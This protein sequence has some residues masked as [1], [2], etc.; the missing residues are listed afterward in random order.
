MQ[1]KH[2]AIL[3]TASC[4]VTVAGCIKDPLTVSP[5]GSYTT[6]NYWRNQTDVLAGITGIYNVLT[7]EIGRAHV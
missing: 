5:V 7:Q 4:L 6:G 2:L 1:R 3:I